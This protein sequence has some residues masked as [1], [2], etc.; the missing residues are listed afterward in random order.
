M[1]NMCGRYTL[2]KTQDRLSDRFNL[3]AK[4]MLEIADSYNVT[5][6][7]TMPVIVEEGGQKIAKMMHWGL[8]PKWIAKPGMRLINARAESLF[9]KP[10]WSQAVKSHRCLIP[11]SGFYEWQLSP[12][13]TKQPFYI[14]SKNQDFMAFAG[15]WEGVKDA[16]G[17]ES[18][19]FSIITTYANKQMSDIHERMPV[20]LKPEE[21]NRWLKPSLGQN[22]VEPMLKPHEGNLE[23]YEVSP[24]V[25]SPHSSGSYLIDRLAV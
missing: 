15:L 17:V 16:E 23:I 18:D 7:Q 3:A 5:P 4:P 2:Y 25:N 6:G 11:A 21:E 1:I 9:T 24:D 12:N 20:I 14:H 19:T 13:G 8:V 22:E 10:T